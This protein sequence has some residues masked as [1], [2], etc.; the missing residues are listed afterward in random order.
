M[1]RD[2]LRAGWRVLQAGRYLVPTEL[3]IRRVFFWSWQSVAELMADGRPRPRLRRDVGLYAIRFCDT[4]RR[5][6]DSRKRHRRS[7]LWRDARRGG[8]LYLPHYLHVWV[9]LVACTRHGA[10]QGWRPLRRGCMV[11]GWLFSLDL[12]VLW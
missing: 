2:F 6:G 9:T 1:G 4:A 8:R 5:C 3:P 11:L 7:F 12:A 10:R